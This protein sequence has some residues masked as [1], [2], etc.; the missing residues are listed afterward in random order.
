MRTHF[1]VALL[2]ERSRRDHAVHA[3]SPKLIREG[4]QTYSVWE[5]YEPLAL[6]TLSLVRDNNQ[7]TMI[8]RISHK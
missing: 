3:E 5:D 7:R 1:N 4:R 8:G 2:F 6:G